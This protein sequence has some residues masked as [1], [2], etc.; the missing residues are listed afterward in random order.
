MFIS[1]TVG[2]YMEHF[3]FPFPGIT[4]F[5]G[6]QPHSQVLVLVSYHEWAKLLSSVPLC[7]FKSRSYYYWASKMSVHEVAKSQIW[8]CNWAHTHTHT[9]NMFRATAKSACTLGILAVRN[10]SNSGSWRAHTL[11]SQLLYTVKDIMFI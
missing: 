10:L 2:R 1:I 3:Y 8:L 5:W 4:V 9:R 7:V 6:A 11:W